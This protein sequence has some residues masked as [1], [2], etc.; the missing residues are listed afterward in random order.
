MAITVHII[1]VKTYY[2]GL[3]LLNVVGLCLRKRPCAKWRHKA[4]RSESLHT[5]WG[6]TLHLACSGITWCIYKA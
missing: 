3:K 5:P 4:K 1:Q 6:P 2:F